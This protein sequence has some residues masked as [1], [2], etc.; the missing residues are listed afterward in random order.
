MQNCMVDLQK[1][2]LG[3]WSSWL[4][5]SKIFLK[6]YFWDTLFVFQGLLRI[7]SIR[8]RIQDDR[9]MFQS[10]SKPINVRSRQNFDFSID[11]KYEWL[12]MRSTG[13]SKILIFATLIN[14]RTDPSFDNMFYYF[15]NTY[16]VVTTYTGVEG[17]QET[18]CKLILWYHAFWAADGR[19]AGRWLKKLSRTFCF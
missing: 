5:W 10:C 12:H 15:I 14:M 6:K 18:G 7:I 16:F 2:S 9:T 17:N 11:F 3:G 4:W 19:P 13:R 8:W 1:E